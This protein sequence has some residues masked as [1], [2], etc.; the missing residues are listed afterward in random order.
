[1]TLRLTI[2]RDSNRYCT[3]MSVQTVTCDSLC[4]IWYSGADIT[5][6][7]ICDGAEVTYFCHEI[8]FYKD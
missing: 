2:Y 3:A 5:V 1:M 8:H 4:D 6:K 7:V